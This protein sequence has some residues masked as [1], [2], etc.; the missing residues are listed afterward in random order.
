LRTSSEISLDPANEDERKEK[1]FC[2][3]VALN[4]SSRPTIS[5]ITDKLR[6]LFPKLAPAQDLVED[7]TGI[8]FG[9]N[10]SMVFIVRTRDCPRR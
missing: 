8:G 6:E 5:D 10:G 1:P 2:A 4:Q 3:L 7:E 9:L